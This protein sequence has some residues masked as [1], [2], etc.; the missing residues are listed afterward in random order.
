MPVWFNS[1]K[2]AQVVAFFA[3]QQ[4]GEINVL[5]LT[6]LVYIADRKNMEAYDFPICGDKL[7]SMDNG[8]VNSMTLN[9]INGLVATK[10]GWDEFVADRAGHFVGTAKQ[11]IPDEDLDEL[12]PAE[13]KTLYAVW[14]D[15]GWMDQW[16]LR[17][18]TH[19]NCPEWEDPDGSSNPI[20]YERVFKF[21]QKNNAEELEARVLEDRQLRVALHAG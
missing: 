3:R 1:R 10:D 9:H 17:D 12:S 7:V 16:Q 8:P 21:L 6:K 5:K 2:A 11:N 4:G 15:F 19:N 14:K 13:L 20:P 18:W